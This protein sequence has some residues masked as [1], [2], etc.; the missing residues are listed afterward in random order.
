MHTFIIFQTVPNFILILIF[1]CSCSRQGTR[2]PVYID[3][4][5]RNAW[6]P[7]MIVTTRCSIQMVIFT[8]YTCLYIYT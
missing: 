6:L 8:V 4:C 2:F 5:L 3:R 7:G 1:P